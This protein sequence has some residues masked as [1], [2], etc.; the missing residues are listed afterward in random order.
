MMR[1]LAVTCVLALTVGVGF[2]G[3]PFGGDDAGTIPAD[4][5]KGPVTKCENR[6][7]KEASK[8]VIAILKCHVDRASGKLANDTMEEQCEATAKTKFETT[9]VTGCAS[10]TNLPMLADDFEGLVDSNNKKVYCTVGTDFGSDDSG[11]LPP[12]APT[13][14]VTKCENVIAK[15]A[16]KLVDAIAKCHI[17]RAVGKLANDTV[18]DQCEATA[19]TKFEVTKVAGCTTC[20][21]LTTLADVV[22]SAVDS[23][24]GLV[25]CAP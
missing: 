21:D 17:A 1:P 24:N 19:K 6:I 11:K 3:T 18:E 7:A 10:C 15:N 23:A 13:G 2:A 9:K 8:L 20:T 14:P 5:P 12:D 25:Y 22:E 16:G 4:A